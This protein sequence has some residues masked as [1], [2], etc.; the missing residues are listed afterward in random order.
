[1][2]QKQ[3]L[4]PCLRDSY[5]LPCTIYCLLLFAALYYL[6]PCT[7]YC[8]VLFTALYY[9]LPCTI[10]RLVL[11][12]ALYYFSDK[13]QY[14]RNTHLLFSVWKLLEL[15]VDTHTYVCVFVFV[16]EK[17]FPMCNDWVCTHMY[18]HVCVWASFS[19]M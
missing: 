15:S 5:L 7:I 17:I 8:I 1:M 9:L 10:Y 12:T 18:V 4:K 11:F 14:N 16:F 13:Y 2:L 3:S 19:S 6:L